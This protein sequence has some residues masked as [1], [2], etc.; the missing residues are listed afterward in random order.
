MCE[1]ITNSSVS[2]IYFL[3]HVLPSV[4]RL[5]ED[6]ILLCKTRSSRLNWV[7]CWILNIFVAVGK[8]VVWSIYLYLLSPDWDLRSASKALHTYICMH[9]SYLLLCVLV[10]SSLLCVCFSSNCNYI[11]AVGLRKS[12]VWMSSFHI[13]ILFIFSWEMNVMCLNSEQLARKK[14]TLANTV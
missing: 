10:Y 14:A 8:V 12:V 6:C 11:F 5:F 7:T 9:T 13:F 3:R 2:Y 4:S 1:W